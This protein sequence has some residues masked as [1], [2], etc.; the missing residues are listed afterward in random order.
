MLKQ[1]CMASGYLS[2]FLMPALLGLGAWFDR[3]YLAFGTA[4]LLFPLARLIFGA[5]RQA[6]TTV[7]HERA[8]TLLD[9]LPALYAVAALGSM[10]VVNVRLHDGAAG[11]STTYA[12][13]IGLSAWITMLFALCPAH[14]LIHRREARDTMVGSFVAGLA[15]YPALAHEHLIHHGR[16]GDT[17]RAE[18]PRLGESVWRFALRRVRRIIAELGAVAI[19]ARHVGPGRRSARN[20]C[21]ASAITLA[22]WSAF[23]V[24]GGLSGFLIYLGVVIGVTFGFQVIT[25]LQHWGLG[26]D[27]VADAAARQL[28]WEEDCQ[29]QAWVTLHISFH[30]AHHQSPRVPYYRLGMADDSPRQ[31]AGYVLLMLLCMIPG[32]WRRLMLPALAHWQQ[33]PSKPWSSGRKLTCFAFYAAEGAVVT[34]VS[35][36]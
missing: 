25:Y 8:A 28:A 5:Y 14:E 6:D 27:N 23:T 18:W 22:T 17:A 9:R 15:G 34:E 3:P 7:W 31:P 36:N 4:M 24:A 16:F 26:D 32:L 35:R 30:Q 11:E 12:V 1:W 20:I 13:G 19:S 33:Q 21:S 10:A 29:F 2:I